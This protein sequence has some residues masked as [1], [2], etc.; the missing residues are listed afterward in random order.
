MVVRRNR[1]KLLTELFINAI[2]CSEGLIE[3]LRT[4]GLTARRY[5]PS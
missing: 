3:V 2:V 5:R 1:E 4:Q